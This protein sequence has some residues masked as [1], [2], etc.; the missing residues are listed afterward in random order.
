MAD[1][2]DESAAARPGDR[3]SDQSL[4]KV[5]ADHGSSSLDGRLG[6]GAVATASVQ[7]S[8]A[9]EA[10]VCQALVEHDAQTSAQV[11]RVVQALEP[12]GD[13]PIEI[14]WRLARHGF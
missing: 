4:A 3:S 5:E 12:V 1:V 11:V 10:S 8:L 7:R 9:G 2:S 14:L 6:E 13:A